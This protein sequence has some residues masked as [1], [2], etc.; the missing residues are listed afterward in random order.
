M[1][2]HSA[3]DFL[4][5]NGKQCVTVISNVPKHPQP[6]SHNHKYRENRINWR[7]QPQRI[8]LGNRPRKKSKRPL[9]MYYHDSKLTGREENRDGTIW[10]R[11]LETVAE[12]SR[13]IKSLTLEKSRYESGKSGE[14][15]FQS[16]WIIKSSSANVRGRARPRKYKNLMHFFV[17]LAW[18]LSKQRERTSDPKSGKHACVQISDRDWFPVTNREE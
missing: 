5:Q 13:R 15:E 10:T 8:L 12:W 17:A 11:F 16:K 3:H 4:Y 18:F 6:L 7:T 14:R 9:E 1:S 2:S